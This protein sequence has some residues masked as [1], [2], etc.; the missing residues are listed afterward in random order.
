MATP[1]RTKPA[2]NPMEADVERLTAQCL[3]FFGCGVGFSSY[4][5]LVSA[6]LV[7]LALA[8]LFIAGGIVL[9]CRRSFHEKTAC[10]QPVEQILMIFK[11]QYLSLFLGIMGLS[12]GLYQK[13]MH[14]LG[15]FA[16]VVA[17]TLILFHVV[18]SMAD[19]S[20]KPVPR[21]SDKSS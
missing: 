10:M 1:A 15:F 16:L 19:S 8:I 14:L 2:P 17:F 6:W 20:S 4:C 18:F 9:L 21:P 11:P 12:V 7:M 5:L 3:S 13:Q